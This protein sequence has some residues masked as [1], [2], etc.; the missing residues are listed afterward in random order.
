MISGKMRTAKAKLLTDDEII[1]ELKRVASVNGGTITI[2]D[3]RA[4]S[5]VISESIVRRRFGSWEA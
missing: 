3:L 5:N 1:Q 4:N 2:G